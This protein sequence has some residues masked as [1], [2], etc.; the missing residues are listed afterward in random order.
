M[1]AI[2]GYVANLTETCELENTFQL[3]NK[4]QVEPNNVEDAD[5]LEEPLPDLKG[6][7]DVKEIH[8]DSAYGSPEVDEAMRKE[9]VQLI[10]TAIRGRKPPDEKLG[11]EDF[12]WDTDD[13]GR[14]QAVTYPGG[15]KAEVQP[16]RKEHR[17]LAH[18]NVQV[19]AGCPLLDACPTHELKRSPRRSLRFSQHELNLALRRIRSADA[20]A[21]GHNLR[22]G[23]ESTVRSLKHP[24]RDGKLPVRGKPRVSMMVIASAATTNIRRIHG[25][26][27]RLTEEKR[28]AREA[29]ER[30]RDA[31]ENAL[32]S[33]LRFLQRPM[34]PKTE[35]K[36]AALGITS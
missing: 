33:L 5:I 9:K 26:V 11:L 2:A 3:I 18:F 25:H 29:Q 24:F 12:E 16:G 36:M 6:R 28:K 7:T 35:L 30:T 34:L 4:V 31:A 14:P 8:T 21:M 13:E 27:Q 19:C 22:A 10:Q 23:A 32:F 20:R 1:K 15:Q 17:Y